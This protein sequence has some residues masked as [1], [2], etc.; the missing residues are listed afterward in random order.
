[1]GFKAAAEY[2]ASLPGGLNAQCFMMH[3]TYARAGAKAK[4]AAGVTQG[5]RPAPA[6]AA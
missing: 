4:A 2:L 5:G 6:C 1:M 3:R